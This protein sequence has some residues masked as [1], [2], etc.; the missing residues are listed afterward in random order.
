MVQTLYPMATPAINRYASSSILAHGP[1][2]APSRAIITSYVEIIRQ[3][4]N[5]LKKRL[6]QRRGGLDYSGSSRQFF[7]LSHEIPTLQAMS[8]RSTWN[9][10]KFLGRYLGFSIFHR[11]F[12]DAYFIVSFYKVVLEKNITLE[13][14]ES[15]D[16]ELHR[17]MT[18]MLE[19]DII[20]IIDETFTTVKERF[21]DPVTIELEPGGADVE[22]TEENKK[23]YVEDNYAKFTDYRGYEL[24]DEVIQSRWPSER[25]SHPLQFATGTSRIPVNGFKDK[26]ILMVRDIYRAWTLNR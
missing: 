1:C 22:V 2:Y 12:L 3:S 16:V 14:L 19:N 7:L 15:M 21:G 10:F 24:N 13:D 26:I 6:V 9:Y 23:E 17:G 20:D 11:R 25:K 5:D 4:P 8:P 18:W